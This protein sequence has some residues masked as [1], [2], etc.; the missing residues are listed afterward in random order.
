MT[1]TFMELGIHFSLPNPIHLFRFIVCTFVVLCVQLITPSHVIIMH[2]IT[3]TS[4]D[5]Q[6]VIKGGH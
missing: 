4:A 3:L 1:F 5:F 6:P 2:V